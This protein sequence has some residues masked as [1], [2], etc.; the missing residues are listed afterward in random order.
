MR[1]AKGPLSEELWGLQPSSHS[2]SLRIEH[3]TGSSMTGGKKKA[4]VKR[5]HE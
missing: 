2:L 1:E 4:E 5:V 3:S